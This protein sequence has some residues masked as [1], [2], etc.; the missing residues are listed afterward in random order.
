VDEL[1]PIEV[2]GH[3]GRSH[4]HVTM[5][6]GDMALYESH[7]ILHG[8]PFPLKS[9]YF[10]NIFIHFEPIGHTL[11]HNSGE[12]D[13]DKDVHKNYSESVNRHQGGHEQSQDG[14]PLDIKEETIE[15]NCWYQRH[16]NN[17]RVSTIL[18]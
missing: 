12:K 4:N 7:Y 18:N 10:A 5:E 13:A 16:P 6:A 11:R 8:R 2:I 9:R 14:L 1:W 3:D 15:A 17:K